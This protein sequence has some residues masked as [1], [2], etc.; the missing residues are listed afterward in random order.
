MLP[1]VTLATMGM[2]VASVIGRFVGD[3]GHAAREGAAQ[4]IAA[5]A[6]AKKTRGDMLRSGIGELWDSQIRGGAMFCLLSAPP[7]AK[8]NR[9]EYPQV[10]TIATV[11]RLATPGGGGGGGAL[12]LFNGNWKRVSNNERRSG[13]FKSF[14]FKQRNGLKDKK[15]VLGVPLA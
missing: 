1:C 11:R 7:S 13:Y 2:I 6:N 3:P 10:A 12:R 9:Q 4:A 14:C 15:K 5:R 8:Q